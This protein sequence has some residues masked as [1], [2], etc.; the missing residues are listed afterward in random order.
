VAFLV[1]F[2]RKH[3]ELIFTSVRAPVM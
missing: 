3:E 2:F 1:Q